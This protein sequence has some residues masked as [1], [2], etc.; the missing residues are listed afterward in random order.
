MRT[1]TA[2]LAAG[3]AFLG[4][5]LFR[6]PSMAATPAPTPPAGALPAPGPTLRVSPIGKRITGWI[7]GSV[8]EVVSAPTRD[9][10]D[11]VLRVVKYPPRPNAVGN[12][13]P[14]SS[15]IT[16]WGN[17]HPVVKQLREIL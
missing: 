16:R 2:V 3:A 9:P 14:V 7:P 17:N 4:W 5:A 6:R 1:S 11:V 8:Y 13:F 12:T 15:T 10:A